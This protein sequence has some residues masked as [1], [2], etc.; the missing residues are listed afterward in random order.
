MGD[1]EGAV[2]LLEDVGAEPR[3]GL[4]MGVGLRDRAR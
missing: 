1:V 2:S 4:G 3:V